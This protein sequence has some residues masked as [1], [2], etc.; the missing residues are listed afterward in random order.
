MDTFERRIDYLARALEAEQFAANATD[1]VV[2]RMH[3]E[4][5][6]AYRSLAKFTRSKAS[7]DDSWAQ[8]FWDAKLDAAERVSDERVLANQPAPVHPTPDELPS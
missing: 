7:A 5:A 2:K 6:S 4:M 8:P 3:F 1:V